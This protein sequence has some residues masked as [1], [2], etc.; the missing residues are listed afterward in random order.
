MVSEREI[1]LYAVQDEHEHIHIS[2]LENVKESE[3]FV[4]FFS[5]LSETGLRRTDIPRDIPSRKG[6]VRRSLDSGVLVHNG[7]LQTVQ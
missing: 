5:C 3:C 6:E 4:I 7:T 2:T 1:F